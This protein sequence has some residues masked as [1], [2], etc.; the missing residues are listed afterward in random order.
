MLCLK[1]SYQLEGKRYS[2][3]RKRALI[4]FKQ[5]ADA[6]VGEKRTRVTTFV[7]FSPAQAV[8][9]SWHDFVKEE[10]SIQMAD[11]AVNPNPEDDTPDP[12]DD[13]ALVDGCDVEIDDATPDEDLPPTEGG[14]A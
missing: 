1:L 8:R 4:H 5:G 7:R 13:E 2:E 12:E 10:R 6:P 11:D 3:G 14:V 9:T